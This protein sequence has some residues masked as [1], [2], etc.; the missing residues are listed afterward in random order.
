M[1]RTKSAAREKGFKIL[2][3]VRSKKTPQYYTRPSQT[4]TYFH[5]ILPKKKKAEIL[6]RH[7]LVN[8]ALTLLLHDSLQKMVASR[9]I[10]LRYKESRIQRYL[11]EQKSQGNIL[12]DNEFKQCRKTLMAKSAEPQRTATRQ[13]QYNSSVPCF[14]RFQ[15][16]SPS[17]F[18]LNQSVALI[19]ISCAVKNQGFCKQL[20]SYTKFALCSDLGQNIPPVR[21]DLP[22]G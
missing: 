11:D 3:M 18:Q 15:T 4:W 21:T 6:K 7:L 14:E 8:L 20:S 19:Q 10:C 13:H 2:L 1:K 12:K 5:D 17:D 16:N 22:L 9:Q